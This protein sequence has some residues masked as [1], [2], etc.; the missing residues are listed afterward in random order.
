MEALAAVSR[1]LRRFYFFKTETLFSHGS[2]GCGEQVP[3]AVLFFQNRDL[4]FKTRGHGPILDSIFQEN[5]RK[6]FSFTRF[7][8]RS[9]LASGSPAQFAGSSLLVFVAAEVVAS[10]AAQ[11]PPPHAPGAR[12]TA[13]NQTPSKK[14]SLF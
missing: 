2:P 5:V 8:S 14:R 6:S 11:T 7:G 1:C 3:P 4:F 12:M 13:V 10:P 9:E